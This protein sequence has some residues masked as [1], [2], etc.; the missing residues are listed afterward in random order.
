MSGCLAYFGLLEALPRRMPSPRARGRHL[1]M[2]DEEQEHY[3]RR[4]LAAGL[5]VLADDAM[6]AFSPLP[7]VDAITAPKAEDL[8]GIYFA[9]DCRN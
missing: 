9:A 5:Y 6:T 3:R 4:L 2:Q 7:T 1:R 8:L